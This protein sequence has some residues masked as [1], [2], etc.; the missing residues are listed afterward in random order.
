VGLDPRSFFALVW[1]VTRVARTLHVISLLAGLGPPVVPGSCRP[2]N[3]LGLLKVL[4]R[5][6]KFQKPAPRTPYGHSAASMAWCPSFLVFK[7]IGIIPPRA[8]RRRF[9]HRVGLSS[10]LY[11]LAR[12]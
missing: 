8:Q 1:Q 2:G 11:G 3:P 9:L 4:P 10:S 12:G 6:A 5:V 7:D